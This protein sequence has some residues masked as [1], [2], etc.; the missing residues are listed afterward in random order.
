[1]SLST[2]YGDFIDRAVHIS[3]LCDIVMEL[4]ERYEICL[5]INT[6]L[7][8]ITCLDD[9]CTTIIEHIKRELRKCHPAKFD[10]DHSVIHMEKYYGLRLFGGLF[11]P[12]IK[13]YE[14]LLPAAHHI[15]DREDGNLLIFNFAHIGYD[16][17]KKTYGAL[18]RHGHSKPTTACGAIISCYEKIRHGTR[19]PKDNDLKLLSKYLNGIINKYD[20]EHQDNGLHL[21]D[22]TVRAYEMQMPWLKSQLT[23]LAVMDNINIM[24]IGGIEVDFSRTCEDITNDKIV[25]MDKFFIDKKG[26]HE[27]LNQLSPLEL[28]TWRNLN[29]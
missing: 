13:T 9:Q 15:P 18:V 6:I 10:D 4:M 28:N 11:I 2:R 29:K 24:Y 14:C 8:I 27:Q 5:G 21:L 19:A 12:K 22:L 26:S 7:V 25:V 20:I 23:A 1:M 16:D 3:E 17:E